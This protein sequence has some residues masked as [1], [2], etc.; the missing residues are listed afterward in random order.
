M[1][2][3]F[4][5]T[6]HF[7]NAFHFIIVLILLLIHDILLHKV[8]NEIAYFLFLKLNSAITIK[9]IDKASTLLWNAPVKLNLHFPEGNCSIT[10]YFFFNQF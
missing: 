1:S 10:F 4:V 9:N 6:V 8:K 5:E 2:N 7:D 3:N